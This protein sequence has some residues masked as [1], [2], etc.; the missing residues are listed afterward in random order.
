MSIYTPAEIVSKLLGIICQNKSMEKESSLTHTE[1]PEKDRR[2]TRRTLLKGV[3][4]Y[5]LVSA[6]GGSERR[7]GF[8]CEPEPGPP[9]EAHI[10]MER[11]EVL[12]EIDLLREGTW[13]MP[14]AEVTPQGMQLAPTGLAIVNK[15]EGGR[16]DPNHPLNISGSRLQVDGDFMVET[17]VQSVAPVHV[18]LYGTPPIR[19][20]DFNYYRSRLELTAHNNR[21]Q[22]RVWDGSSQTPSV[23][24]FGCEAATDYTLG[25]R[26]EGDNLVLL[27]NEEP[28]GTL[29]NGTIFDTNQVWFGLNS[30]QGNALVSQLRAKPLG[31]SKMEVVDTSTIAITQPSPQGLQTLVTDPNFKVGVAASI[32]QLMFD[33]QYAQLVGGGNF[34]SITT[35]NAKPQDLQPKEGVYTFEY[36]DALVDTAARLGLSKVRLHTLMY[37]KALPQWMQDLPLDTEAQRRRA[38]EAYET[39]I[40]TVASHFKDRVD[41]IDVT[42]EVIAGMVPLKDPPRV[43]DQIIFYKAYGGE[44]YIDR[45]FQVAHEAAPNAKLFLNEFGIGHLYDILGRADALH[46]LVSRMKQ[47]GAPIHGV[48]FEGHIVDT[49][50]LPAD[51]PGISVRDSMPYAHLLRRLNQSADLGVAVEITE[52]DIPGR[53][54]NEA[55][56]C[57][58][59]E[60]AAKVAAAA[61]D[62][63]NCTGLTFWG[64]NDTYGSR[65]W[66]NQQGQLVPA[67]DLPYD[68]LNRPKA[69]KHAVAETLRRRR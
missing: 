13:H 40:Y 16:Y 21:L 6:L 24:E 2:F 27:V 4:A 51:I 11:K 59:A 65:A 17:R 64:A 46:G 25:V 12:T 22:A 49:L 1:P 28:V 36:T 18:Q 69:F 3:G 62:A 41:I 68:T 55:D 53:S 61:L 66:I 38:R 29:P 7:N 44:Q 63:R 20:D 26:R 39:H 60:Q 58:Q 37:S 5:A 43:D 48:G 33:E 57:D 32:N 19:F 56:V 47:R 52:L 23:N 8:E 34:G 31:G 42:N 67:N 45:F 35:E 30:E 50:D 15:R 54:G 9:T 10:S 14:G